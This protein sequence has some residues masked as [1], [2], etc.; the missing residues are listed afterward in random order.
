MKLIVSFAENPYFSSVGFE[1]F[2]TVTKKVVF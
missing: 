1:V 2:T